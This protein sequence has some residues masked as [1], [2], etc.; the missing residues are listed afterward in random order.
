MIGQPSC[1]I[2]R[3]GDGFQITFGV[4][5]E[6]SPLAE[7]SDDR[8]RIAV[9]VTFNDG[10]VAVGVNDF[11]QA[12]KGIVVK[13]IDNRSRKGVDGAQVAA[14]SAETIKFVPSLEIITISVAVNPFIIDDKYLI[15]L[16]PESVI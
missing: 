13:G 6:S 2:G 16:F 10:D 12:A 1:F 15:R 7:G 5:R 11:D 14:I 4:D 8:C 3:V 9:G